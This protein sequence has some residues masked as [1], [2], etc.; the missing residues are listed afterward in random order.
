MWKRVWH[1]DA[2][3]LCK[4]GQVV[5]ASIK[6]TLFDE[7]GKILG[8]E[9]SMRDYAYANCG[10]PW[11]CELINVSDPSYSWNF[12]R[13]VDDYVMRIQELAKVQ[14]D[15]PVAAP[16]EVEERLKKPVV[17]MKPKVPSQEELEN[18]QR[19][20]A[21]ELEAHREIIALVASRND[22]ETVVLQNMTIISGI[23]KRGRTC[24]AMT[25]G[26]EIEPYR[27]DG[28]D[29]DAEVQRDANRRFCNWL[30]NLVREEAFSQL[31]E[32]EAAE[33]PSA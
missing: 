26:F 1:K 9:V 3:V 2:W 19:S 32:L 15:T 18:I 27:V 31:E 5:L 23:D 28:Q 21:E 13:R 12:F 8:T 29:E 22:L 33:Q 6:G 10:A 4:D 17:V 25:K 16:V 30:Q 14:S 7:K 24:M 20:Y 11:A